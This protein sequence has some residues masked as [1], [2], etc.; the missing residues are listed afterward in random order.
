MKFAASFIVLGLGVATSFTLQAATQ[1]PQLSTLFMA[2]RVGVFFGTSTGSTE[3]AAE[4]IAEKLGAEGPFD[5][6]GDGIVKSFSEF[7]SLIVGTPTWNTGKSRVRWNFCVC[8]LDG[9]HRTTYPLF[10]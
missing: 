10:L 1:R 9:A 6:D 3:T 2:N 7:D 5:V 4:M 8:V